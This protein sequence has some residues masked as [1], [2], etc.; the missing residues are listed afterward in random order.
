MRCLIGSLEGGVGSSDGNVFEAVEVVVI[1]SG[2]E[3]LLKGRGEGES[4][5]FSSCNL[6]IAT[7]C[8]MSAGW[9]AVTSRRRWGLKIE[10]KQLR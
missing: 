9:R 2:L 6:A 1:G 4:L 3:N 10:M 7:A 8:G 5:D